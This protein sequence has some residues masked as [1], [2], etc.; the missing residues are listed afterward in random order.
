M[1][2]ANGRWHRATAQFG[3]CNVPRTVETLSLWQRSL[4]NARN[5]VMLRELSWRYAM[6]CIPGKTGAQKRIQAMGQFRAYNR[7]SCSVNTA[8]E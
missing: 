7:A 8:G 2:F 3:W 4:A 1:Q 6:P 5:R